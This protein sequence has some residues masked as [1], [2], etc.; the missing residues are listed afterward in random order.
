MGEP[1]SRYSWHKIAGGEYRA[2]IH[3]VVLQLAPF[4]DLWWET[5]V[6]FF[7]HDW[8][9][10]FAGLLGHV[11]FL[12]RWVVT[13]NFYDSYFV[14][15]EPDSFKSRLPADHVEEYGARDLGWKGPRG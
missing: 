4:D 14:V 2:Q 9:M 5:E 13:F 10:P 12:D 1:G 8:G 15:E 11:G 7:E 6:H 3:V